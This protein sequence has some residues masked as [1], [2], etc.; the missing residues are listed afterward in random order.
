MHSCEGGLEQDLADTQADLETV[1]GAVADAYGATS[2]VAQSMQASGD[3]LEA[4]GEAT[5]SPLAQEAKAV[6]GPLT[7]AAEDLSTLDAEMGQALSEA[8]AGDVTTFDGRKEA[9]ASVAR[10]S[11]LLDA[12]DEAIPAAESWTDRTFPSAEAPEDFENTFVP[13]LRQVEADLE[14]RQSVCTGDLTG[15]PMVGLSYDE[16]TMACDALA[17]KSSE[18]HCI[19]V[20][21]FELPGQESLCFMYKEL[22][23]L[24]VFNCDYDGDGAVEVAAPEKTEAFMQLVRKHHKHHK[25]H[26]HA[27]KKHVR[28]HKAVEA[29]HHERA[30]FTHPA[31]K[32]F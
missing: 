22:T 24:T 13:I 6:A 5:A 19:A 27:A 3:A 2:E 30:L 11:D 17:P 20:Q 14:S 29:V 25:H 4:L 9:E 18:D 15:T 8:A 10:M 32:Y 31:A 1:Q 21:Y 16:C 23:E 28:K 12:A 7:R 26:K